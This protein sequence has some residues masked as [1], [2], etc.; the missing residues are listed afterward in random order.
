MESDNF[1]LK[2]DHEELSYYNDIFSEVKSLILRINLQVYQQKMNE[3]ISIVS[4]LLFSE[5]ILNWM[6][7]GMSY[8]IPKFQEI[9]KN[10]NR[11][12]VLKSPNQVH[13]SEEEKDIELDEV[14]KMNFT[15]STLMVLKQFKLEMKK[16]E[17]LKIFIHDSIVNEFVSI[18]KMILYSSTS[19][20]QIPNFV[21]EAMYSIYLKSLFYQQED[22]LLHVSSILNIL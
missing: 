5:L 20:D 9:Q 13:E 22:I 11:I 12:S 18:L 10:K 17:N 15:I 1:I 14:K 2:K 6:S 19:D 8:Q 7:S 21:F 4:K 16:N 3:G